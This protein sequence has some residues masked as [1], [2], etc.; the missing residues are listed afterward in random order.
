MY[1]A[2]MTGADM[3]CRKAFLGYTL[4]AFDHLIGSLTVTS[5]TA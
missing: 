4:N 3:L 2:I 1:N 5:L